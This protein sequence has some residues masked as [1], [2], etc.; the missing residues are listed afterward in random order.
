MASPRSQ[1]SLHLMWHICR[2]VF[3]R[4]RDSES[5]MYNDLQPVPSVP[6]LWK[7][8]GVR[9][10]IVTKSRPFG[11]LQD[12]WVY[13]RSACKIQQTVEEIIFDIC[14]SEEWSLSVRV[15][16][17]IWILWQNRNN[18][19]WNNTKLSAIQL[20]TQSYH[21]WTKLH[22]VFVHQVFVHQNQY[23]NTSITQVETS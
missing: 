21:I 1:K 13:S 9:C 15:A 12:S 18:W 17:M 3:R 6:M 16:V 23:N 8:S 19:V 2:A 5:K 11:R 10:L 20:G 7:T 14:S 22:Q 4:V